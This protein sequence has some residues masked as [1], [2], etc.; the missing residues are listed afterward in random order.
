MITSAENKQHTSKGLAT[1][2]IAVNKYTEEPSSIPSFSN[3][4]SST[5]N[6]HQTPAEQS[7]KR[8]SSPLKVVTNITASPH[9]SK[10]PS[11]S[12]QHPSPAINGFRISHPLRI[13]TTLDQGPRTAQLPNETTPKARRWSSF[14]QCPRR[15][16]FPSSRKDGFEYIRVLRAEAKFAREKGVSAA[17]FNQS[18]PSTKRRKRS[19]SGIPSRN[20]EYFTG[21][22][23]V[24]SISDVRTR[25]STTSGAIPPT[26]PVP[27]RQGSHITGGSSNMSPRL[28]NIR[29][30]VT[31]SN[32]A[33]NLPSTL[34]DYLMLEMET[35][36]IK[37][38]EEYKKE[39]LYNFLRIPENLEKVFS[40]TGQMLTLVN[41]VWMGC[42]S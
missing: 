36:E 2:L 13:K 9:T 35:S 16:S 15:H 37:V 39:R 40:S 3:G 41:L 22:P 20:D 33:E 12:F 25:S 31:R 29:R 8:P 1:D 28:E 34:W 19:E 32:V 30:E 17:I 6:D 14:T 23:S 42:L 26:L 4:S 21:K 38:V 10:I 11:P 18:G 24:S 5:I 27:I 7:G